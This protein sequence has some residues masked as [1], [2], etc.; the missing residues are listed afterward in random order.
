MQITELYI[1]LMTHFR[2]YKCNL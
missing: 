1:A 2:Q